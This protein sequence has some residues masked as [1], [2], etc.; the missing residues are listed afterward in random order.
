MTD[1]EILRAARELISDLAHWCQGKLARDEDGVPCY[2]G[3]E[4]AEQWCAQGAH[5]RFTRGNVISGPLWDFLNGV[6]R[7]GFGLSASGV[8]DQLGHAAVLELYDR[9]IAEL[10]LAGGT[11]P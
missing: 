11:V 9:A 4:D 2:P 6:A 5:A 3:S 1:L 7:R 10:E 8:N